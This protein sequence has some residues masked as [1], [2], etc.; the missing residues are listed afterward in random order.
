[1]TN[2]LPLSCGIKRISIRRF[3][4]GKGDI[5]RVRN[6]LGIAILTT[7]KGVLTGFQVERLE[8]LVVKFLLRVILNLNYV[9]KTCVYIKASSE[10]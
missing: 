10:V 1:M 8:K 3:Y 9:W 4:V 5:P 6:G 7:P 2:L